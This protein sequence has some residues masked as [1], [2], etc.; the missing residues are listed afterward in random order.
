M[1]HENVGEWFVGCD[2]VNLRKGGFAPGNG[3]PSLSLRID[4]IEPRWSIPSNHRE[5][6]LDVHWVRSCLRGVRDTTREFWSGWGKE[7]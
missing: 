7:G 4:G 3:G 2:S 1:G 6:S 5:G